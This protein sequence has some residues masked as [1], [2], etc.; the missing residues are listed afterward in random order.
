[1]TG[2]QYVPLGATDMAAVVKDIAALHP[3][4]V[5]N[6]LNGDS[7]LHFFRALHEAGISA[8]KTPVFSTSVAEV[9]LAAM[10]ADLTTGHYAA[11]NYFQS[12]DNAE[13]KAFVERFKQRF[14]RDRVLDDP[15][16]ASYIGVKLW[17]NA[18]RSMSSTDIKLV[19]TILAQQTLHAPEGIVA[20]DYATGHLWKTVLIGKARADGQF[21]VVWESPQPVRPAPFP[22]YRSHAEWLAAQRALLRAQP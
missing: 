14:G 15:M 1:M 4:F 7:N 17:V 11:W 5:L 22:F 3:D 20:V 10:G 19:K 8:E 12:L 2:E 21:D 6:T 18:A 16:E 13:N 9:G